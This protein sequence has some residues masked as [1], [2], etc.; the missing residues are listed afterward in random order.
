MI[1]TMMPTTKRAGALVLGLMAFACGTKEIELR[2]RSQEIGAPSEPAPGEPSEEPTVVQTPVVEAP[3]DA[4]E[5]PLING[6]VVP[7]G[8]LPSV[9]EVPPAPV[10]LDKGC[11]KIDFLFVIDNSD[12][13]E[14][15]QANLVTSFP[16][17]INVMQQ[18]LEASDF[19]IMV[20][21]TGG[22][23]EDEDEP[24][25]DAA[26]CEQIQGAGRR[27][28]VDGADC[29]IAGGLPFM[30][31]GP[32]LE[33][34]FSCVARVGTKGSAFEEPIDAIAA[35]TGAALN[36]PGRCNSGFLREDAILVVTIITDEEDRRSEGDP[37]EWRQ[38]LLHVKGGNE[39]AVVLLGL[40]GDNNVDDGLLGGPCRAVDADGSPRLQEFVSSMGGVLGSVCAPD[41]TPFFQT[42]VGSINSSCSDFSPPL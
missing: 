27:R 29:G 2:D 18:V 1:R 39:D 7:S 3:S 34:T 26:D 5:T 6:P 16:G 21:S 11:Q 31:D 36:A 42:A 10:G 17:F 24:T 19:H 33:A 28:S 30:V 8:P 37:D 9:F 12:S 35:A 15:E 25:L 22:D 32:N 40:V 14:D 23:R 41:Y 13:M 38:A 20:V 4:E